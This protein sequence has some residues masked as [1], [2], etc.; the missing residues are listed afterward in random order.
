VGS[1]HW[2]ILFPYYFF[3]ALA[4]LGVLMVVSRLLRIKTSI[5]TLIGISIAVSV[6]DLVVVFAFDF[7]EIGDFR[8]WPLLAIFAVSLVCATLDNL[9]QGKL[10]LPLDDELAAIDEK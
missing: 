8:F 1:L 4:Y 6:I 9:L 2:L 3:I 10:P 7:V 5:N